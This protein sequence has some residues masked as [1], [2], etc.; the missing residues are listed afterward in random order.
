MDC[1]ISLSGTIIYLYPAEAAAPGNGLSKSTDHAQSRST[2]QQDELQNFEHRD[3][4]YE[5]SDLFRNN[6]SWLRK[7]LV[8]S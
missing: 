4:S 5:G 1:V 7:A 8:T 2:L 3:E 6:L